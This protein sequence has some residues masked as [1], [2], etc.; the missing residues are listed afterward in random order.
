MFFQDK[1]RFAGHDIPQNAAADSGDD[2]E[3]D[4]QKMISSVACF[5]AGIDSCDGKSGKADGVQNVHDFFVA[6]HV[7]AAEQMRSEAE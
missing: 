6:F 2:A 3:K 1:R 5:H 4:N 7:A